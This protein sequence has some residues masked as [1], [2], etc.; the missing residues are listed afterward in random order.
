MEAWISRK[1][2]CHWGGP[3]Q[4]TVWKSHFIVALQGYLDEA[5]CISLPRTRILATGG[6][7][8][9]KEILQVLSDV[10]SAPVYTIDTANSA[11]L[12]CAYRAIHGL[13][14]ETSVSLVDVVK[15]A[16]EPRLVVTPTTGADQL[17]QPLLKRYAELE[18]KILYSPVSSHLAK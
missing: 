9:N 12:G 8:Y 7:S 10:F 15:L 3:D 16:P 4:G 13:V 2:G 14:A 18:Q 11:C 1:P 17:Y 5:Q 6:A